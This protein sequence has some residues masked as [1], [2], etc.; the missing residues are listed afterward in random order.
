MVVLRSDRSRS[1]R[2]GGGASSSQQVARMLDLTKMQMRLESHASKILYFKDDDIWIEAKPLVLYLEYSSTNVTQ[3]LSIVK[4][5]NKKSLKELLDTRGPSKLVDLSDKSTP[6]YH[7]LKSL[8]V[9]EPGLY[10]L[11]FRST[12]KQ[13]QDFQDWVCEDVLTEIRRRGSYGVS[14]GNQSAELRLWFDGNLKLALKSRDELQLALKTRD[15]ELQLALKTR[16]DELQLALKSRDDELQLALKT[17]DAEMES[18]LQKAAES[19][20]QRTASNILD[21]FKLFVAEQLAQFADWR[22]SLRTAFDEAVV[23]ARNG[24]FLQIGRQ[25]GVGGAHLRGQEKLLSE[26]RQIPADQFEMF[27][28]SGSM[29]CVSSFLESSLEPE[30]QYIIRHFMPTKIFI[31]TTTV[32]RTSLNLSTANTLGANRFRD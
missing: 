24:G 19:Q 23:A 7:E 6:G 2:A 32:H 13:A 21:G 30:Q 12:K 20:I 18:R 15:D 16:D 10:S 29:L 27:R 25:A 22:A 26:C 1:P 5:K 8:Y 28:H 17:R 31:L 11:I 4:E 3:T 14:G 9:N